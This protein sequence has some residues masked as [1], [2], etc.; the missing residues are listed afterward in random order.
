MLSPRACLGSVFQRLHTSR[1]SRG[2][3][4]LRYGHIRILVYRGEPFKRFTCI[5]LLNKLMLTLGYDEY[6]ECQ[7]IYG[8][9][10]S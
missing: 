2:L 7:C 4:M 6:D 1:G 8:D 10:R 9:L 3:S 5:Q